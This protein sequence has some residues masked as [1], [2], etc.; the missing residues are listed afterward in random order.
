MHFISLG[1]LECP[2]RRST[3]SVNKTW[4]NGSCNDPIMFYSS[5]WVQRYFIC[6]KRTCRTIFMVMV[7][8]LWIYNFQ[9][10]KVVQKWHVRC[11]WWSTHFTD[12][13]GILLVKF[14]RA[15][16]KLWICKD[17]VQFCLFKLKTELDLI[18]ARHLARCDWS[19]TVRADHALDR[20]KGRWI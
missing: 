1:T 9:W 13:I 8:Q 16:L 7:I 6:W 5:H 18:R 20:P 17:L 4:A 10:T 12:S 11:S 3:R 15:E 19:I 14:G 2:F